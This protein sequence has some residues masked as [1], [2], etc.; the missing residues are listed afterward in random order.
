MVV[1]DAFF[2]GKNCGGG[3]RFVLVR[4]AWNGR[5]KWGNEG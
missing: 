2:V 5:G 1:V 4:L 3:G